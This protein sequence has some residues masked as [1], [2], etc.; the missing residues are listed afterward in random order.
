MNSSDIFRIIIWRQIFGFQEFHTTNSTVGD[1]SNIRVL[2]LVDKIYT[3]VVSQV[4]I[5][6]KEIIGL[7]LYC[8][9]S[10]LGWPGWYFLRGV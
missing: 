8:S 1:L 10:Y 7:G 2:L 4:T 5:G 9:Y 3:T 6:S